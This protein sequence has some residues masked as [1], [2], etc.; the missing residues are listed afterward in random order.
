MRWEE[1][2]AGWM[3]MTR[4]VRADWPCAVADSAPVVAFLDP[5]RATDAKA[6]TPPLDGPMP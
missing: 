6:A 2:E 4:R 5:G 1:I 3:A